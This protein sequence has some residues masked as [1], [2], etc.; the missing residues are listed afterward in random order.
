MRKKGS[1][2]VIVRVVMSLYYGA[3][4]KVK[5]GREF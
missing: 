2:E 1:P 3:K 4:T 5:V